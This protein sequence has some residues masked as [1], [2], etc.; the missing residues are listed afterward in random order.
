MQRHLAE[1]MPIEQQR[2]TSRASIRY[3]LH[4]VTDNVVVYRSK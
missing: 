2:E 4:E 3:D 1:V